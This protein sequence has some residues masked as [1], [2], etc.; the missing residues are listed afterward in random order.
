MHVY[1]KS[2]KHTGLVS[3]DHWMYPFVNEKW[4]KITVRY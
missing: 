1:V 2:V 4:N 3:I